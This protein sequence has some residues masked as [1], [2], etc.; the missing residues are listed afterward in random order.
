MNVQS[1]AGVAVPATPSG[2]LV[3]PDSETKA[4][5]HDME[6]SEKYVPFGILNDL[7]IKAVAGRTATV[8]H[9]LVS[10]VHPA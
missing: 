10:A 6:W 1:T 4:Q 7:R 8:S 2:V 9:H 5:D 3:D